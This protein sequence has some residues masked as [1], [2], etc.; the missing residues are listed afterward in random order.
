[1]SHSVSDDTAAFILGAGASKPL[2]PLQTELIADLW[3]KSSKPY[4]PDFPINRLWPAKVYLR[5]TFPGLPVNSPSFE[6]VVGPLEISEAEEY[7]YQ[8]CRSGP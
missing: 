8:L 1:M 6:D 3:K 5:R 2:A 7:W 4:A